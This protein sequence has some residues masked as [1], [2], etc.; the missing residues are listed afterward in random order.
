MEH[1]P[2]GWCGC[3][4]ILG[5]RPETRAMRLDGVYYFEKVTQ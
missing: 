4:N 3:V 5:Q 2:P 1:Q